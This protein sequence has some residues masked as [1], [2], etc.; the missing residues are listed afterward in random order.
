VLVKY[1]VEVAA[2]S[3]RLA[4]ESNRLACGVHHDA[5]IKTQTTHSV[6]AF[7]GGISSNRGNSF[8]PKIAQKDPLSPTK[9]SKT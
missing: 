3:L 4:L 2:A 8:E 7:R 9:V 5:K 1:I 6:S